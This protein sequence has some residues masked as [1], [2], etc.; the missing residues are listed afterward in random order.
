MSFLRKLKKWWVGD[1]DKKGVSEKKMVSPPPHKRLLGGARMSKHKGFLCQASGQACVPD[2]RTDTRGDA[3]EDNQETSPRQHEPAAEEDMAMMSPETIA[4]IQREN[5]ERAEAD[6]K[7]PLLIEEKDTE[8]VKRTLEA[9]KHVPFLGD[10]IPRG[11]KHV[12]DLTLHMRPGHRHAVY[13]GHLLF[14]D[15]S[16]FGKGKDPAL[17][18]EELHEAFLDLHTEIGDFYVG[19]FNAGQFQLHLAVFQRED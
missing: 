7:L 6:G 15:S 12:E 18:I 9:C 11:Y 10:Y 16:G 4:A 19:I 5:A 13:Q 1:G 2:L 14:V 17:N 3:G 8:T